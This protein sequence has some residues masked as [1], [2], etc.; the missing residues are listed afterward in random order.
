MKFKKKM[1]TFTCHVEIHF[2]PDVEFFFYIYEV[3]L[4]FSVV[5]LIYFTNSYIFFF[6]IPS[7]E[8]TTISVANTSYTF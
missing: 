4:L 1:L 5:E 8:I 2:R 6:Q 7:T 3:T